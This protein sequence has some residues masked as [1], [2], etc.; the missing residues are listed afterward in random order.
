[1]P[2]VCDA[3]A[4]L[5]SKPVDISKYG[6]IYA[7]AHKNFST[8]GV[9]YTVIR[10]DLITPDVLPG[11]PTMCNWY[12]FSSAPNKVWTVPITLSVWMGQ[13][14]M[15]WMLER[16]GLPY[17]EDLAI[18]RSDLLYNLI[19]N[20]SGFYRCFVTETKF[21]SRMQVV[22]T[23]RSGI[24][25]DEILVQKFLDETDKLGWLDA[26]SHPLGISSDAIR[27]TMYNPQPYETIMKAR[28]IHV[29]LLGTGA[30]YSADP[31]VPGRV[32]N[33][34]D[35]PNTT[36]KLVYTE[37]RKKLEELLVYFDNALILRTLY[38]VSSDLDSRG[39]IGKLARFE[40]VHKV[41]TSVTV[42]DDLCPLIPEL[43]RRRTTG[44]LNFVNSGM[45]TY[46]DVVSDLAKRAPASWRR[47]LLGQE[48]N[49]RA[50]AEL[51]VARLAAACGREVP[52]ARSS[53]QRMISGL[54]DDELQ[55]LAPQQSP[56]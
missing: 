29:T 8:A 44:V 41:Q 2:L 33:E 20:S 30:L 42:L 47:P 26:R 31:Q 45:V 10:K 3:S 34:E 32:F 52:D 11:T 1:M 14:V 23:V 43:V 12:R 9:C 48:D 17:F 35:P 38:P 15:E 5:G 25:A 39:L 4:N 37:L 49:S 16:G 24:G 40:Q 13:L 51:G 50:A 55:T 56:L 21:R 19:D 28:G 22:F 54:T 18:R 53:L 6:V 27:I 46:T 36:S 7:A